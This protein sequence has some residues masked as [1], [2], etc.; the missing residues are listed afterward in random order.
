[1]MAPC[2]TPTA[3]VL[4]MATGPAKVPD[5]ATQ[6]TP[7]I[8]PLPFCEQKPAGAGPAGPGGARGGVAAF[9]AG[10]VGDGIPPARRAVKRDAQRPGPRLAARRRGVRSGLVRRRVL[11]HG[12]GLPV[13]SRAGW[14]DR[15]VIHR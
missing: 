8:S 1:M 14:R 2:A 6:E 11:G 3:W 9:P 10:H 12:R 5:S 7:V 15:L 13:T 4:V